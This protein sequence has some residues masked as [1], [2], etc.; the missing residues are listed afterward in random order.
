M[1]KSVL[2]CT[3]SICFVI[4][5]AIASYSLGQG[6]S[7]EHGSTHNAHV[8][9]R[10]HESMLQGYHL[11]YHLLDLP[12]RKERHLMTYIADG[13]GQSVTKGD[14]GYLVVGPDGSNQK[15]MAT[16]MKDAFGADVNFNIKGRYIIKI[17]A[18]FNDKKLLDEFSFEEK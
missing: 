13:N 2:I 8:G 14:L 10:I 11:A 3:V 9:K 17:K 15:V 16:A 6:K 7:S 18:V 12:G 5:F 4:I 1:K